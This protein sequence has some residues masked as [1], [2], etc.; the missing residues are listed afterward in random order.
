MGQPLMLTAQSYF[1]QAEGHA[2]GLVGT[3]ADAKA[4]FEKGIE[5]SFRYLYK[6]NT[7][8]INTG[9]D[10]VLAAKDYITNNNTSYLANLEQ[11]TSLEVQVEAIVTQNYIALSCK[12]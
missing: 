10:S 9:R 1:V 2:R 6:N 3:A 5:S 4:K 7:I 8:G 11:A 12:S